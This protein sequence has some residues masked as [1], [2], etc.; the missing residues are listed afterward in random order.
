[1]QFYSGLFQSIDVVSFWKSA[2]LS[3][4]NAMLS[5]LLSK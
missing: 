1:M 4:V 5:T 2:S 3:S